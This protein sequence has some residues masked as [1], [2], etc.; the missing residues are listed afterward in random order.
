MQFFCSAIIGPAPTIII[1][2]QCH[3]WDHCG[4]EKGGKKMTTHLYLRQQAGVSEECVK[5][6]QI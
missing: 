4:R 3:V 1:C 6:F 5:L 2:A